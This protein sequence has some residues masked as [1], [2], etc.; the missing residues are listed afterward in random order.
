MIE[1]SGRSSCK[2]LKYAHLGFR[3]RHQREFNRLARACDHQMHPQTIKVAPLA[4]DVAS[5]RFAV[6]CMWLNSATLD[7]N[8]VAYRYRQRVHHIGLFGVVP[9]EKFGQ[10]RKEPLP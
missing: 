3:T 6:F 1:P 5:E 10:Q 4:G 2:S 7:A 9:F 8:V